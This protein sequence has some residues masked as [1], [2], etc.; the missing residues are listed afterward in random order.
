MSEFVSNAP[1]CFREA[2]FLTCIA[3]L[4]TLATR[5]RVNYCYDLKPHALLFQVIVCGEQSGGKS[6]ARDIEQVIMRPLRL[7]DAEQRRREQAYRELKMKSPGAKK[8]PDPPKTMI[9]TCPI[10]ISIAQ[11]VK[12]CDAPVRYYGAPLTLWTFTDELASATESNRRAFSNL[13]TIMRTA[14]DLGSEFGVDYLSDT[15][16]SATVD[17]LYNTMF[18]AT[19]S[20]LDDYMDD[21]AVEGG[22]ITRTIV[23]DL[24]SSLG[25]E[26]ALFRPVSPAQQSVIDSTLRRMME[27]VYLPD[28]SIAPERHLDMSFLYK[29]VRRWVSQRGVEAIMSGSRAWD[30]FRKRSSVS[31]FRAATLCA[32][33]YDGCEGWQKRC[34]RIYLFLA[35]Y[36]LNGMMRH[37]GGRFEALSARRAPVINLY[38]VSLFDQLTPEFT[39]DQLVEL[40]ARLELSTPARIFVSKWKKLRLIREE[41][42]NRYVKL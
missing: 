37:W 15:S 28:G 6:F 20:A 34:R 41:A 13:K 40:I 42:P 8:L 10:S 23:V 29:D 36:I 32:Y 38:P 11:L 30:V 3:P 17:I 7:H 35:D 39:R 9:R 25:D 2:A 21:R 22:N 16:Y 4:A 31:A 18:C 27:D 24:E 19:Y 26:A 33:L 5:V 1:A 12:R 14:Y